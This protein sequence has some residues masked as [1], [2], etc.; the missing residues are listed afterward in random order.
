MGIKN[1]LKF[2]NE[3]AP[4]A[5]RSIPIDNLRGKKIGIDASILVYQACT[6]QNSQ[7]II[8]NNGKFVGHLYNIFYRTM[9]LLRLGAIP[10]FVFDNKPPT[11]KSAKIAERRAIKNG[12]KNMAGA[13]YPT[14]EIFNEVIELLIALGI[15]IFMAPSEADSQLAEFSK[16][17]T[18]DYILSEDTDPIVFGG[19]TLIKGFSA[20]TKNVTQIKLSAILTSLNLSMDGF[21]DLCILFGCDYSKTIPRVGYK[22][23]WRLMKKYGAIEKI[24]DAEKFAPVA[25]NYVPARRIF[26]APETIKLRADLIEP[27]FD[28]ATIADLLIKKFGLSE[29]K[30]HKFLKMKL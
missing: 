17:G 15:K 11:E 29:S 12:K 3:Y 30:I 26:I 24:L 28:E 20:N 14:A 7:N 6:C 22:N 1:L 5:V 2:L 8:N 16:N 25:F 23:S 21:I 18:I 13:I 4:D 9:A 27:T 19:E 10:F